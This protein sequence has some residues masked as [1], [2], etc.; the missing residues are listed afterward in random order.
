MLIT[1]N[2][3][4]AGNLLYCDGDIGTRLG[5]RKENLETS[6]H[7]PP[8]HQDFQNHTFTLKKANLLNTQD[9]P[10]LRCLF[11]AIEKDS[12]VPVLGQVLRLGGSVADVCMRQDGVRELVENAELYHLVEEFFGAKEIVRKIKRSAYN[13][14]EREIHY[15][16][17]T[18]NVEKS[19][20]RIQQIAKIDVHSQS[21][22]EWSKWIGQLTEDELF[23]SHFAT[24]RHTKGARL[25]RCYDDQYDQL[26][27]RILK[28]GVNIEEI[29][30]LID[31]A[32]STREYEEITRRG[33]KRTVR[34][35]F[36]RFLGERP[37]KTIGEGE[38]IIFAK[39]KRDLNHIN[40][41]TA[42]M[43][44]EPFLLMYLQLQHLYQGARLHRQM[45]EKG[46][47]VCFPQITEKG[48]MHIEN[49]LPV[50]MVLESISQ[51]T[52]TPMC[53]NTFSFQE[54]EKVVQI[55]GPN[56]NGKSEAWRTMHLYRTL[57]NA[58]YPVPAKHCA[59][60][61]STPSHFIHC[62]TGSG[63]GG[64]ELERNLNHTLESLR[65]MKP[66]DWVVLD[67]FGDAA[68]G[69]TAI[70]IA[71]RLLPSILDTGSQIFITTQHDRLAEYVK[72][73][74]GITLMPNTNASG[75][76]RYK[77]LP[78]TG[79]VDFL[80]GETLDS[81]GLTQEGINAVLRGERTPHLKRFNE[82][83]ERI[84]ADEREHREWLRNSDD[85]WPF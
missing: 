50:R 71:K 79:N 69:P 10:E 30:D 15:Q 80:P 28:P 8:T 47:P 1:K 37:E 45:E 83:K 58:G 68:N 27:L 55:E 33:R 4:A 54:N 23:Q 40:H 24:Y 36:V 6:R 85:D 56:K 12:P 73:L 32:I 52:K 31:C 14:S 48:G 51:G 11:D 81:M 34:K 65:S 53:T 20:A 26:T 16:F 22:K 46:Y 7:I 9:D 82:E 44:L 62:K 77:L 76:E 66:G 38:E 59:H 2:H 39:A 41:I 64:S 67:E 25:I 84:Q 5:L 78:S 61:G 70:E 60:S 17:I 72:D 43:I 63:Y 3:Y 57:A 35:N 74:G 13:A 42:E 75:I 19:F 29:S 18:E 21:W 49:I